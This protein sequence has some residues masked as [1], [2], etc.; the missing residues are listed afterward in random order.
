MLDF[1]TGWILGKLLNK[2]K[3]VV[4][5][6]ILEPEPKKELPKVYK[7]VHSLIYM[8]FD[9]TLETSYQDYEDV[10]LSSDT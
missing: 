2:P 9:A 7:Y 8:I 4:E 3:K 1:I 5:P 6:I 10:D